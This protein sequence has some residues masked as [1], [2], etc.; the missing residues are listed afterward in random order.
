MK[1]EHAP[2]SSNIMVAA[3]AGTGK[4][5]SMVSRVAYL[6]NRTADAVVDIVSDIAMITFTKDAAENMNRRL[7]RMFMNYFVLTSNEKYMHL[8]ED[9]S[10]IRLLQ[11]IN[12]QFHYYVKNVCEWASV[13]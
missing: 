4:T 5:Y 10:Q 6:C 1:L 2:S 8:V 9:M 12:L 13:L 7:K 3:G 11:F